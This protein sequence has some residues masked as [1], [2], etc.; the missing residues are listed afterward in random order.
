MY[1][2]MNKYIR[3]VPIET[4]TPMN[5][6]NES[7]IA[8]HRTAPEKL[9]SILRTGLLCR[10]ATRKF[11]NLRGIWLGKTPNYHGVKLFGDALLGVEGDGEGTQGSVCASEGRT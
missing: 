6:H 5:E 10:K 1:V 2:L 3:F 11:N 9:N 4:S 8:W 7:E